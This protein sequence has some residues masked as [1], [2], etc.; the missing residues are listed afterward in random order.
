MAIHKLAERM[1]P[2]WTN[3]HPKTT[4]LLQTSRT[5]TTEMSAQALVQG[6][7]ELQ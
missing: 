5:T 6:I 3:L 1:R 7:L 2:I 4:Q